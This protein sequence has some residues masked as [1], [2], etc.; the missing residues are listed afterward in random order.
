MQLIT[1]LA[2]AMVIAHA[3]AAPNAM[4]QI[5]AIFDRQVVTTDRFCVGGAIVCE[6]AGD[7]PTC[8]VRC[9]FNCRCPPDNGGGH[10]DKSSCGVNPGNGDAGFEDC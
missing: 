6:Y 5:A 7:A 2:L 3:A 8:I 1:P 4:R 10:N 9:V